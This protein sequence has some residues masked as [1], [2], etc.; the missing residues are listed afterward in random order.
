MTRP[1]KCAFW[2]V[3]LTQIGL[4]A[5]VSAQAPYSNLDRLP[6]EAREVLTD[7]LLPRITTSDLFDLDADGNE[8]IILMSQSP[9]VSGPDASDLSDLLFQSLLMILK[10]LNLRIK[11]SPTKSPS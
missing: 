10:E 2:V 1:Q 8:E 9:L 11:P 6:V 5:G 7:T 4:V 3:L